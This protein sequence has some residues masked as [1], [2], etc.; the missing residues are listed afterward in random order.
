MK[1]KKFCEGVT[2]QTMW[3]SM[4]WGIRRKDGI[5]SLKLNKRNRNLNGRTHDT[6]FVDCFIALLAYH[7]ISII[8]AVFG[9]ARECILISFIHI[10]IPRK[11]MAAY[12][13]DGVW[14]LGL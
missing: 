14:I 6:R 10:N 4:D 13:T 7:I 8:L 9:N 5:R 3:E 11:E 2:L 12:C 1:R